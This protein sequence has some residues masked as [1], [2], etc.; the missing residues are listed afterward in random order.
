MYVFQFF[1]RHMEN[2]LFRSQLML[3]GDYS[4]CGSQNTYKSIALDLDNDV[5]VVVAT[6]TNLTL[7]VTDPFASRPSF[8]VAYTDGTNYIWVKNGA[9]SG[10]WFFNIIGAHPNDACSFKVYQKKF[11]FGGVSQYTPDYDIFWSFA[12]SLTNA[13]LFRQPVVN[14][15]AAPVFHVT[16]YP[17]F[18]SMDRVHANLQIYAIRDGQQVEV[19]GSSGMW[20][21]ACEFNFYFPPF[22]CR[23]PD[24]VLY[25]NFFARDR[26]DMTLQ[27]AGTMYCAA[28]HPT[29]PPDHV[30]QN[31]GVMNPA[32]TTCVCTP[33]WNGQ[34]CQNIACYNGGTPAGDHCVCPPGYAGESCE[35]A[36]CIETG[37]N[38][39][40]IRKGVD[41]VFAVELTQQ[42]IASV[43]M[44]NA[45]FQEIL[46]DVLMQD[47]GWIRN[48][49]L[50]G[51]NSTWGGPIAESP[52]ENLTAVINAM[53][54]ISSS[55]PTDT[56]CT[57]KLWDALNHAI[58]ARELSPGSFVEIFQTTPEDD[59][60]IRSLGLF[61]D[62]SRSMDLV[63][64]GFLASNPRNSPE[65]FVCN[66][67][68]EKYYT[69]FG[70]VSGST[71]TTYSIQ[72]AEISNAV[73]LIPLQFSN[74]QVTFNM[75]QDCRHDDG[76]I[77]YFPVDAYTQT[78][79]ID[80]FGYGTTLQ[81]YNGDGVLAE[82]LELFYDDFTG[83]SVY[84]VRKA[85]DDGWEPFGQYCVKFLASTEQIL[86]FPQAKNFCAAAGGF[87]ADDLSDDKN[88]FLY[89][90]AAR[91]Q[92][93]I[94]L[95][96]NG[97]QYY[98]DRGTGIP[99]SPLNQPQTF[100]ADGQ[101][102]Q[103]D[104]L[105]QCTYFDGRSND[106]NKV[107][108][109]DSC[110]TPR[111]FICQKHRYDSDHRP[112]EIGTDDLPAGHWYAK[113]KSNPANGYPPLCTLSVRVQSSLQIVTGF[114]TDIGSDFPQPD[115]TQDSSANRLITYVHSSDNENRSPILTDAILWDAYNG[116]FYNGLKYQNRFACQYGWV[117][118]NFPCP[119]GDSQANEFGVLHLGED[120]FGNT[121]QR[122]TYGHCS[123]AIITCGNGGI[124]QNGQCVCTD[125]YTGSRCTI[126]I[127]VNGGTRNSDEA[128]CT[129]PA[130]YSGP[131]CQF[132]RRF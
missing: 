100:W 12:T 39:E 105:A 29:P 101:P 53:S 90:A 58:F 26:T 44:L 59:T 70:I 62:M 14:F 64:Y 114:A 32:N 40:F 118:Q 102:N 22:T 23:V 50:V 19:Y 4:H 132:G 10:Q 28:F 9:V 98:W 71:G 35:L 52:A 43:A 74:G 126:P 112:N 24:E 91:T 18:I 61:Y 130:G 94:G 89:S 49:V 110:S 47:R 77:T 93:W 54:S 84:E 95:F 6:G 117:S 33:Q 56:G 21:D 131:N 78:I 88:N 85:C 36:R 81:V 20:R 87:L 55:V 37:P 120:E 57:V 2:T 46:R 122:M 27:R 109:T 103:D 125:Y 92:F 111:P 99:A 1:Y 16:N 15:D 127:C 123:K 116:T 67:T 65:G 73:R 96:K 38:P 42:S 79:Q 8:D 121:F 41:M 68:V 11:N 48:F 75:D 63:L 80:T 107:W 113:L 72:P 69:L 30:C 104:H 119:N 66:A 82:A 51:F 45:N 25:F 115:P 86:P 124:R 5:L 106:G 34:Y 128:T 83:Q 7:L 97:D 76:L 108:T 60:D 3:S 31:G 13:G 17:Q 129:C